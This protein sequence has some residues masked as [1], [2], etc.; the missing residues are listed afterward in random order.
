MKDEL[1]YEDH[2]RGDCE[3]EGVEI[4]SCPFAEDIYNDPSDQCT[5]CDSCVQECMDGI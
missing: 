1:Y 4:H 5:C 3:A 2:N